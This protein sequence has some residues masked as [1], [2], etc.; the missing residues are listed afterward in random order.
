LS[1]AII[2]GIHNFKQGDKGV[3][4]TI[5]TFDGLHLGH[6][7]I[8]KRLGS[9]SRENGLAPIAIT[10]EP[11]PRVLV[12]PDEPPPLLTTWIEK[13][14]LFRSYLDG[15]LIVLEFNRELM[16]LSAEEFV[17]NFMIKKLNLKRLI[18]GYDHA[19][20]KNRSG[21]IN[22]LMGLGR[23]FGFDL[24]VVNPI[25]REG[26]PISSTRIR[27]L[28]QGHKL[29]QALEMLGH[30]YPIAGKVIQGIGLGKKIGYPT[31][32]IDFHPRKL[33]PTDGVYSCRIEMR[34]ELFKGMMFIGNNH[35]NPETSKSVEVNIF[36]FKEEIYGEIIICQPQVFIRENRFFDDTS[37]LVDQIGLDKKEVLK[38]IDKGDD[39]NV[40]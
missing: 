18:V 39:T 35:F 9:Y 10:F 8:L 37:K 7:A 13:T 12:T 15:S 32:N 36:D 29:T 34:N 17:H 40:N 20:G 33:L 1:L 19:F 2:E 5:G 11:H 21:T 26:R 31:A 38:L 22:D 25:I 6:Q 24:E 16:N 3:V 14:N 23:K 28:I 30:P 4:A 27:R